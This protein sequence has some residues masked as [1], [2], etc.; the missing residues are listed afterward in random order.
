MKWIRP[1]IAGIALAFISSAHAQPALRMAYVAPPP[2]WGPIADRFAKEVADRTNAELKIQSF[3]A[4]QLGS[5]PQNY[6]GLRTGQI[7]MMLADTG[8]L[9]LA[10]GGKDFNAL[11]AP[12][13][14]RDHAHFKTFMQ[15]DTFRQMLDGVEKEA[16][17]KLV[18]Y[19]SDR[20]PRQLTTSNRKV[21]KP[22]DMKGLK[23]RV[24]ETPAILEVMKGWGASPTPVPAAELYLAMKQGL[25]DGQDNGF[26]AIAGA[27]YYE[28]Q[29]YAMKI[30]YIQ[31]GLIVLI[32]AD[33]W[34]R[35]TPAQ[36]KAM[37]DAAVATEKWASKETWDGAARSIETLK[38]NGMEIVEPD[39]AAF[40]KL[41]DGI[42]ANFDGQLWSKGTVEKIRAAK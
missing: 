16:G 35:L 42:V 19:V 24:P 37:T 27:K 28:V 29:K 14:F 40:R 7:D 3:G 17:F 41:A 1:L 22:E 13:V 15:S 38:A 31:S 34:A 8:T 5:L 30:D 20:T 39:L 6:A 11:F 33:K 2:V 25:V 26:D 18:G 12:Y 23:V 10:K 32:A 4:G 21:L 9:A 36:Q